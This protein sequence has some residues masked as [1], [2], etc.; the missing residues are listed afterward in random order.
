MSTPFLDLL[1]TP[2]RKLAPPG[3]KGALNTDGEKVPLKAV[4]GG[5]VCVTP[6]SPCL[7]QNTPKTT[8]AHTALIMST[9]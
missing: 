7:L 9:V 3:V 5:K 1:I 4:I 8:G 2:A 6:I